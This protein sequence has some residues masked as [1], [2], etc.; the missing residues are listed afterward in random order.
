MKIA[1]ICSNGR[2]VWGKVM[3]WIEGLSRE[4]DK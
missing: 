3:A 1:I 4:R 2:A